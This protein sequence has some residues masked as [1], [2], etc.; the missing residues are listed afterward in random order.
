MS[1]IL[2]P[3]DP[4]FPVESSCGEA[5]FQTFLR[6]L[7][8]APLQRKRYGVGSLGGIGTSR[9]PQGALH[10]V[11][12]MSDPAKRLSFSDSSLKVMF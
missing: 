1:R 7:S 3:T 6:L 11:E 12:G 4:F 9:I 10:L 5:D 2:I 8:F